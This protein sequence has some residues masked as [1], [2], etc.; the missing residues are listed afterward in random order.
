MKLERIQ[1]GIKEAHRLAEKSINVLKTKGAE[2]SPAFHLWFGESNATPQ[3]VD[4]LLKEHYQTA[5]SH[6]S[7]SKTPTRISFNKVPKFWAIKG[8]SKPTSRS[9]VYACPPDNDAAKLCGPGKLA[10]AV[11]EQRTEGQGGKSALTGPTILGF[12][13][14]YFKHGVFT[15][16]ID[17]VVKY[18]KDRKVDKPSRGFLLLHELQRFSKATFPNPPAEDLNEPSGNKKCYSPECCSK[19]PDSEKI[20]NAQ[21]YALFAL[22]VA[23]SPATKTPTS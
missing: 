15:K 3:M 17:M 10:A 5:L 2:T 8:N 16:N 23:A 6:L 7:F 18:R 9:I 22:D 11:Y 4:T 12:C 14:N 19:L 13:P 21:N 20:R 1:Y